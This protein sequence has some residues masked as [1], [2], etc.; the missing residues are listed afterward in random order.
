[1][2]RTP[3]TIIAAQTDTSG[4]PIAFNVTDADA[5]TFLIMDYLGVVEEMRASTRQLA[6]DWIAANPH[7]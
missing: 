6:K 1:M 4:D 5:H 2:N 3:R 7:T